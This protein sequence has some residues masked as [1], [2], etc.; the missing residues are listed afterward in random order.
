[1]GDKDNNM[2]RLLTA[3]TVCVFVAAPAHAALIK[4]E[5]SAEIDSIGFST[6]D[7]VPPDLVA[8]FLALRGQSIL[9]SFFY[10]NEAP[11]LLPPTPTLAIYTPAVFDLQATVASDAVVTGAT[12]AAVVRNDGIPNARDAFSLAV[13]VQP[14]ASL[15]QLLG[16]DVRTFGIAW[17]EGVPQENDPLPPFLSDNSLPSVLPTELRAQ[18]NIGVFVPG[19][20]PSFPNATTNVSVGTLSG[21]IRPAQIPEPSSLSLVAFAVMACWRLRQR[22]R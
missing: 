17:V 16:F 4:Y 8:A 22:A 14:P 7:P 6:F 15:G 5:L 21:T 20:T 1:L 19:L 13:S 10:D 11:S 2:K 18:I 9:G 3:L 12:G